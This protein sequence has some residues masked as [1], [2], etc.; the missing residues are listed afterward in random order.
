MEPNGKDIVVL[1]IVD[2]R[3]GLDFKAFL[4]FARTIFHT[5]IVLSTSEGEVASS[6]SA[7]VREQD[8]KWYVLIIRPTDEFIPP[9]FQRR[10]EAGVA[11]Q[12]PSGRTHE[13]RPHVSTRNT[14]F[15]LCGLPHAQ[16]LSR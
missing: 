12:E 9:Q 4:L 11:L 8:G 1:K 15:R 6:S 14:Y 3:D 10:A 16:F 13:P 5:R 2:T 7:T